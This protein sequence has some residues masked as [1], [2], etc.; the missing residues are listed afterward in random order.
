MTNPTLWMKS[1]WLIYKR[2]IFL[3]DYLAEFF[4]DVEGPL[5]AA[6]RKLDDLSTEID[7]KLGESTGE[8]DEN[9]EE[10]VDSGDDTK[11]ENW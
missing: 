5:D 11:Q 4:N 9:D 6:V 2:I 7:D 10:I 1:V 3:T 8:E